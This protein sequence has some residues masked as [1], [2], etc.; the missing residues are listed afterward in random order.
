MGTSFPLWIGHH[1]NKYFHAY[2]FV[3][4]QAGCKENFI[5]DQIYEQIKI[6]L[7]CFNPQLI[8]ELKIV[9]TQYNYD[10]WHK[11]IKDDQEIFI[12]P[13]SQQKKENL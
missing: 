8:E 3:K 6:D 1:K 13:F 9:K 2:A 7:A 10:M 12:H 4:W 11:N 5:I